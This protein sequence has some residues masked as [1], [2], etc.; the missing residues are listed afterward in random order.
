MPLAAHH[1]LLSFNNAFDIVRA[2]VIAVELQ[3]IVGVPTAVSVKNGLPVGAAVNG[4][5]AGHADVAVLAAAARQASP[6]GATHDCL[7]V[8]VP[9]DSGALLALA[10]LDL[11]AVIAPQI[12]SSGR[13]ALPELPK[14]LRVVTM[15]YG[16][17]DRLLE[18]EG[19][20][21]H[22]HYGLLFE[23]VEG[24]AVPRATMERTSAAA[25]VPLSAVALAT[26]VVR[27]SLHRAM[28]AAVAGRTVAVVAAVQSEGEAVNQLAARLAERSDGTRSA[29]ALVVASA[30]D[31]H[32]SGLL[33]ALR[34]LGAHCLLQPNELHAGAADALPTGFVQPLGRR[35]IRRW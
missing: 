14:Q 26:T 27:H 8:T 2:W 7:A 9:L 15:D 29:D 5:G 32:D 18:Q 31:L 19:R 24:P 16:A 35:L 17:F 23:E 12:T 1:G 22:S 6:H 10:E 28:C 3:H 30:V 4:T 25:A 20:Q 21:V 11:D 33:L 13:S 34:G